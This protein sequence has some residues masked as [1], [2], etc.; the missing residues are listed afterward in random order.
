MFQGW[1][2]SLSSERVIGWI[3]S[4]T[5]LPKKRGSI[6]RNCTFKKSVRPVC[7]CRTTHTR[8]LEGSQGRFLKPP[9]FAV[10]LVEK[11]GQLPRVDAVAVF[12]EEACRNTRSF[13]KGF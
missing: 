6:F 1:R 9:G 13:T 10:A 3:N 11:T 2:T 4:P 5:V 12:D 8:F 7:S